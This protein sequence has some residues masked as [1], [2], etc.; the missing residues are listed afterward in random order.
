[1]RTSHVICLILAILFT[2]G[3]MVAGGSSQKDWLT[4]PEQND[5]GT[6]ETPSD[7]IGGAIGEI[8]KGCARGL[9]AGVFGVMA[10][11]LGAIGLIFSA[12]GWNARP[13]G[14]KLAFR[15]L[16]V[17]KGLS[18]LAALLVPLLLKAAG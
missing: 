6:P 8:A 15:I 18:V 1:M 17:L 4:P 10:A 2:A 5:T 7:V 11:I 3:A 14:A 16:Q 12:V 9:A 13:R